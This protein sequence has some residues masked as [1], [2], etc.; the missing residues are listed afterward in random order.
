MFQVSENCHMAQIQ[1]CGLYSGYSRTYPHVQSITN[2]RSETYHHPFSRPV[3][4]ILVFRVSSF[5]SFL[6]PSFFPGASLNLSSYNFFFFFI[7]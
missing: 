2:V 7:S 6:L 4:V 5:D 3:L 1:R